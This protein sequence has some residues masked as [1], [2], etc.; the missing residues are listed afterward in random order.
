MVSVQSKP[1]LCVKVDDV[2]VS[3]QIL[4]SQKYMENAI[5]ANEESALA[6]VAS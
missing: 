4:Y 3:G 2:R 5:M 6:K 1:R